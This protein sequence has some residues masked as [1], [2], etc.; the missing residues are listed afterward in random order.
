MKISIIVPTLNE[1]ANIGRLI[2]H[3]LAKHPQNKQIIIV[4]GGSTDDTVAIAKSLNLPV[5]TCEA[6]R[7][8]QLN[9][10][11]TL[12]E[13][14]NLYF[15]HS[16]TLPPIDFYEDIHEAIEMG[17]EAMCYRSEFVDG[18]KMLKLNSFFTR[19]DW[20]VSRGGDQS[21]F[22][23]KTKFNDLGRFNEDMQVMEEYPLIKTLLDTSAIHLN[24]KKIKIS[25]RK[26]RNNSWLR[27]SRANYLAFRMFQKGEDSAKIKARYH[28]L[29]K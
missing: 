22:I 24:P 27:V 18:P 1:S 12:S 29:L 16:D 13:H 15:V 17:K 19:F 2:P 10:G 4:D 26:Y 5:Q 7:A 9:L 23:T 20:L 3:L 6:S 28:S 8:K 21:L 25:T 14:P 11:A